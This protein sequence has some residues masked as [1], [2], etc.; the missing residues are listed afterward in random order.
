MTSSI[1][2]RLVRLV[3]ADHHDSTSMHEREKWARS[4]DTL[5]EIAAESP[6]SYSSVVIRHRML[7]PCVESLRA[8]VGVLRSPSQSVSPL[9]MRELRTFICDGTSSPLHGSDPEVAAAGARSVASLFRIDLRDTHHDR[10][11]A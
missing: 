4:V 6:P 5:L 10:M 3:D 8:I 9:A 1:I 11:A 7:L 2:D